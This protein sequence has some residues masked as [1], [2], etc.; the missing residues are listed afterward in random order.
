MPSRVDPLRLAQSGSKLEGEVETGRMSRLQDYLHADTAPQVWLSASFASDSA[1]R[2]LLD[3]RVE[4]RVEMTCQRCLEAVMLEVTGEFT[5]GV[6]R[7][8]DEEA[9][10]PDDV[11]PFVMERGPELDLAELA[12]D[13]VIL[14]LPVIPRHESSEQCGERAAV[15]A[16]QEEEQPDVAAQA[17]ASDEEQAAGQKENPFAV[18]RELKDDKSED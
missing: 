18:L 6:I 16:A 4:A 5:I 13:E 15:L 11:D 7:S 14:A 3:G 8:A 9:G 12:E 10:L 1:G 2:I 17:A